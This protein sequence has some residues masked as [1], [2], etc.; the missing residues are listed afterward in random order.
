MLP[1]LIWM[2]IAFKQWKG[3]LRGDGGSGAREECRPA[4]FPCLCVGIGRDRRY[5]E[6][7]IQVGMEG[8]GVHRAWVRGPTR[9]PCHGVGTQ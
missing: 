4:R 5:Y 7:V 6:A 1:F 2:T 9:S 3:Y 8:L